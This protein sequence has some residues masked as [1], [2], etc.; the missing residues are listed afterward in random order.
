MELPESVCRIRQLQHQWRDERDAN[1]RI[2]FFKEGLDSF[3]DVPYRDDSDPRHTLDMYLPSGAG[4][5]PVVIEIHGGGFVAC[6]KEINR[7]HTRWMA[8]QGFKGVNGEYTL[9]PEG[10]FRMNMQEIADIV[11]WVETHAEEYGFDLDHVYMTGD[12]AGGF[13]VLLYAM[14]Q[15]SEKIRAHFATELP[16]TRLKAVAPTAPCIRVAYDPAVDYAP[17]ALPKMMFP[18]GADPA[19]NEWLDILEL[20]K[21]SEYPPLFVT[22]TPSDQLLYNDALMLRQRLEE[23]GREFGFGSYEGRKNKLEH[24]FNVLYPEYE[25]SEKANTDIL[26][27]FRLY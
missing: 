22:T 16:K 9:H 26:S 13:L 3:L 12:S 1:G 24:V 7:I 25:E 11:R 8:M 19:E 17:D 21:K 10:S 20:M 27:F 18:N 15:G 4:L 6:E 5:L 2:D 14:I 23:R